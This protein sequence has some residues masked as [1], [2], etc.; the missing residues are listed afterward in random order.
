MAYPEAALLIL[1]F[2]LLNPKSLEN[3]ES[4]WVPELRQALE[5]EDRPVILCGCKHDLWLESAGQ[6]DVISRVELEKAADRLGATRWLMTSAKTGYGVLP[7]QLDQR[8]TSLHTVLVT[9]GS[10]Q[11]LTQLAEEIGQSAP[12]PAQPVSAKVAMLAV[13]DALTEPTPYDRAMAA[14]QLTHEKCQQSHLG[15]VPSALPKGPLTEADNSMVVRTQSMRNAYTDQQARVASR[16]RE[17]S[18]AI[19]SMAIKQREQIQQTEAQCRHEAAQQELSHRMEA[20]HEALIKTIDRRNPNR[21]RF[22]KEPVDVC[23]ADILRGYCKTLG[24]LH[25]G[26]TGRLIRDRGC[27]NTGGGADHYVFE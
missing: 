20:R 27:F 2:D 22:P 13:C 5:Y 9:L 12:G 17:L 6:P 4:V 14:L 3:L 15:Y 10:Q 1:A 23:D 11:L 7:E 26:G 8:G 25:L 16:S 18:A 24:L 21:H 19:R